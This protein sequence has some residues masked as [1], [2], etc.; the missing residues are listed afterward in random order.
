[1]GRRDSV[2]FGFALA[3][4]LGSVGE[5]VHRS[6]HALGFVGNASELQSHLDASQRG[7]HGEVVGVA[8]MAGAKHLAGNLAEASAQRYVEMFQSRLAERIRIVPGRQEDGRE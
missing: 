2:L 5:V 3:A 1:P 6:A 8:E 7:N 4:E